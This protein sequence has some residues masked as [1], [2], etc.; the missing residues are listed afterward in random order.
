MVA[1]RPGTR[2]EHLVTHRA[3]EVAANYE[4]AV[5]RAYSEVESALAAESELAEREAALESATKQSLGARDEADRRYRAGLADIIT[6]LAS[7]RTA[8]DSESQLLNIRRLRLDN[9]V[10]LHLALGGGFE[11][12]KGLS[13]VSQQQ[14][15]E[16]KIKARK[17]AQGS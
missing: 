3:R 6:V 10:D 13:D 9:R 4:S 11:T 1:D 15:F 8:F 2:F 7:Q 16:Q 12:S 5:L 17:E 14:P